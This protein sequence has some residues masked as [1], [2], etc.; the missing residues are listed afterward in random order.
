MG[1]EKIAAP[2]IQQTAQ[3]SEVRHVLVVQDTSEFNY[4]H[5]AGY[6]SRTDED[7]GPTGN[8]IDIGFFVHPSIVIDKET[9][10]LLGAS[11]IHLWNRRYDKQDKHE[12]K[13]AGQP[14]EDKES[15]RWIACAQR[16]KEALNGAASILLIS[17]RESD[18][19]EEFAL[20]PDERCDVLIRSRDNRRLYGKQEKLYEYLK[21]Q[22]EA[23]SISVQIRQASKRQARQATLKVRFAKVQIAR[24]KK[25][26]ADSALPEYIELNAICVEETSHS[27]PPGEKP[28]CWVLLTTGSVNN[29]TDALEQ[30]RCYGLRWQIELV[31]ASMKSKGVDTE[32]SQLE[33]GRALKSITVMALITALRVNQLRLARDDKTN[34]AAT[35]IFTDAQIK[36]LEVLTGKLEGNTAKQKNPHAKGT[37]AWAAWVIG[38]LGGWK[39]Y[40]SESP[41]GNK[42]MYAGWK[43]FIRLF[44]GWSL[45][46]ISP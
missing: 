45:A 3:A 44:E 14:I 16:S 35:I 19:Y 10:L 1:Y 8:D 22:P 17:D 18:I 30:I 12:R 7:L 29:L 42:T 25:H 39:G 43:D 34:T 21:A 9:S 13:Y 32:A 38:R 46:Q 15:Y 11:D 20:I 27:V 24:P 31:F 5:H 4:E 26:T 36:L 23:G 41:P 37:I 6:L 33:T 2:L 28:I 40:Q